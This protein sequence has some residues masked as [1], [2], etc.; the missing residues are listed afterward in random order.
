[1]RILLI[2]DYLP[3]PAFSG[4]T[5]RVYNLV[6]RIAS[7]HRVSI[8]ALFESLN[9]AQSIAHLKEFCE[10]VIVVNHEW[11]SP[12]TCLPDIPKYI[13]AGSPLELRLLYSSKMA[14]EIRR[15]THENDFDIVQIEHSRLALYREYI[16]PHA[17]AMTALTFHNVTYNQFD[18]LTSIEKNPINRFRS[19]VF[20]RQFRHWEPNYAGKFDRCFTVS[21]IDRQTLL[22]QNARLK[23][24]VLPNGTDTKKLGQLEANRDSPNLLFVGSMNYLP[25][26]DGA[27]F[28]CNQILPYIREKVPNIQ[29]WLVGANPPPG[30]THLQNKNIHVTG[31]VEDVVP[32]YKQAAISVVPIRAGGGTRLKILEAMALGRPVVSTTVGCEGIDAIHGQHLLISDDPQNFAENV[33]RLLSNPALY[34]QIVGAARQLAI[35]KYDW[36][37]VAQKSLEIYEDMKSHHKANDG[38]TARRIQSK[39]DGR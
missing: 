20:S 27:I 12:W 32:Y 6:K 18:R 16:D 15:L 25:C 29:V 38:K 30:I 5:I 19:W 7:H 9:S 35:E 23:I 1:M 39:R 2:T 10:D 11:P 36:D 34:Q 14:D 31:F 4:D 8:L 33:I 3:Y 26:T 17:R 13:M 22:S 24:D 37:A 21:K 28:F